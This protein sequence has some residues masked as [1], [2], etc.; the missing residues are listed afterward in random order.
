M[1]IHRR[2]P[3]SQT[4]DSELLHLVQSQGAHNWVRIAHYLRTRSPKQCRERYHQNL[5]QSLNHEP[6]S[7][8]EGI[9]IE[10]LVGEMGKRW[11]EIARRLRGRSD[12]AVKN[13]WNGGMNRRRRLVIRRGDP[14]RTVDHFDEREQPLSFARPVALEHHRQPAVRTTVVSPPRPAGDNSPIPSPS[15]QSEFSND[16]APPSLVSDSSSR[17]SLS[18]GMEHAPAALPPLSSTYGEARRPSLP[19]LHVGSHVGSNHFVSDADMQGS[20]FSARLESERKPAESR[21]SSQSTPCRQ[22][23][24]P[25]SA[26][27]ARPNHLY[28]GPQGGNTSP[29]EQGRVQL[30]P[31]STLTSSFEQRSPGHLEP[32]DRRMNLATLIC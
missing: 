10:R 1:G 28:A 27:I 14:S 22:P 31:F 15:N 11:A 18:P 12:N 9:I 25:S 26:G 8:E 2:G 3:W 5:K 4:E 7:P 29:S 23:E 30:P 17:L 24:R 19:I 13:W 6:I 21:N 20:V 16:G 32:R